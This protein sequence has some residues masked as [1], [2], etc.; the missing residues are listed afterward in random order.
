[1]FFQREKIHEPA[2]FSKRPRINWKADADSDQIKERFDFGY[3]GF[4]FTPRDR[5]LN[6][7]GL[8]FT[9]FHIFVRV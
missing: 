2:P 4:I 6:W 3:V 5:L 7:L 9:K 1:M 8:T